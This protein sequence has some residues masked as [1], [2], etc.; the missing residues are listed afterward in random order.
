[1]CPFSFEF[2]SFPQALCQ[3]RTT[4]SVL[5]AAADYTKHHLQRIEPVEQ[6]RNASFTIC[7]LVSWLLFEIFT[8]PVNAEL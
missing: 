2:Y 5:S 4:L 1:M 7:Q 8:Y 3:Q 6:S